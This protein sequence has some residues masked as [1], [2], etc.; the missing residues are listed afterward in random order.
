MASKESSE[1]ALLLPP[2]PQLRPLTDI[3]RVRT[4]DILVT[5]TVTFEGF[6]STSMDEQE[7]VFRVAAS[8]RARTKTAEAMKQTNE[9]AEQS[10]RALE[11]FFQLQRS[12]V[13]PQ[14]I[15]GIEYS[16]A[17]DEKEEP[18]PSDEDPLFLDRVLGEG[19]NGETIAVEVDQPIRL[20]EARS[21]TLGE[22][23]PDLLGVAVVAAATHSISPPKTKHAYIAHCVSNVW[24]R[25]HVSGGTAR[26]NVT[27]SGISIGSAAASTGQTTPYIG[28]AMTHRYT[29]DISVTRL[30][31]GTASYYVTA[32]WYIGT[33][34]E[35]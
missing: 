3:R 9:A 15:D 28:A 23:S 27:R 1:S 12:D 14:T 34:G 32:G 30:S 22:P 13:D 26:L 35:C 8:G 18:A 25:M 31:S 5:P 21:R 10:L 19:D 2:D 16:P 20:G 4:G 11:V 17:P 33:G 24:V 29:F 7:F 6:Y